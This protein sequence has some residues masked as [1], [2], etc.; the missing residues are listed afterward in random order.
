MRPLPNDPAVICGMSP[1]IA[2]NY[3]IVRKEL[4]PLIERIHKA[5]CYL[6]KFEKIRP[7]GVCQTLGWIGRG[8]MHDASTITDYLENEYASEQ[9]VHEALRNLKQ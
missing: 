5:G 7:T 8:L 4:C 1:Q 2:R 3:V 9:T 6:S